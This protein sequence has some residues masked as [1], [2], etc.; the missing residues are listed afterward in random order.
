M[1]S[2]REKYQQQKQ[3]MQNRQKEQ[4]EKPKEE[5]YT[6]IYDKEK[7]PPGIQIWNCGDATHIIDVLT[8]PAG[9]RH[10]EVVNGKIKQDTLVWEMDV[11]EHTNVGVRNDSYVCPNMTYRR[12]DPICEYMS[13]AGR[14]PKAEYDK[15]KPKH[16]VAYLI[17]CH[18]STEEENKGPQIW[19]ISHFFF[20]GHIDE[21]VKITGPSGIVGV[22]PYYDPDQGESIVFSKIKKGKDNTEYNG[23]RFQP[24]VQ[25]IPDWVLEK[26]Y[27]HL[28]DCIK[29]EPSYDEIYKAF[30]GAP[31]TS[32]EPPPPL[33]LTAGSSAQPGGTNAPPSP[34]GESAPPST[35]PPPPPAS[36]PS[37]QTPAPQSTAAASPPVNPPPAT[38]AASAPSTVVCPGGGT[39]GVDF[40][41]LN[42]CKNEC[43]VWDNCADES[44]RIER[45]KKV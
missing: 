35:P 29:L 24:R 40:N 10:P 28:D 19:V 11:Y 17:W 6:S 41:G 8:W 20:G 14:L 3:D 18:D 12:T 1:S 26:A 5:R 9:P 4:A 38:T 16:R 21:I 22:R 23:H 7:I 39:F 42:L 25:P 15:I 37:P 32:E 30:Y 27:F 13:K 43:P 2:A 36:V 45:S 31:R 34:G 33:H 44:E